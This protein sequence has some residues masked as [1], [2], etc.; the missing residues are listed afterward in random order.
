MTVFPSDPIET[1]PFLFCTCLCCY[2][3]I[4]TPKET[5]TALKQNNQALKEQ[6]DAL[7]KEVLKEAFTTE[8]VANSGDNR[9]VNF[10]HRNCEKSTIFERR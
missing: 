4:I 1:F 2:S 3:S 10:E 5:V 7:S 9:N 6:V 8:G